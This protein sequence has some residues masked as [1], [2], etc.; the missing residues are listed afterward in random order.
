MITLCPTTAFV[1]HHLK[2]RQKIKKQAEMAA[3]Q[4]AH[5]VVE[6]IENI[7]QTCAPKATPMS[8]LMCTSSILLID[9][10]LHLEEVGEERFTS[11]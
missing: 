9:L 3:E 8:S 6:A 11:L 4:E 1:R 5:F 10:D 2:R 7:Q